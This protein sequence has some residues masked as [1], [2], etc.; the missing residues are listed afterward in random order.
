MSS[1][2]HP[3]DVEVDAKALPLLVAT[4]SLLDLVLR[5]TTSSID[6]ASVYIV[7][8]ALAAFL[9]VSLED[10]FNG[11]DGSV[12][13]EEVNVAVRALRFDIRRERQLSRTGR[14]ETITITSGSPSC[15]PSAAPTTISRGSIIDDA[16]DS[17][18]YQPS[19]ILTTS[20]SAKFRGHPS[21][22][23]YHPHDL[24]KL[25]YASFRDSKEGISL[26]DFLETSADPILRSVTDT[27][28][29]PT[30]YAAFAAGEASFA[31]PM[32]E[33]GSAV[34]EG[35]DI[36]TSIIPHSDA[37]ITPSSADATTTTFRNDPMDVIFVTMS[38]LIFFAMV[39]LIYVH[40]ST[41][42]GPSH[43]ERIRHFFAPGA[44]RTG[45]SASIYNTGS[46]ENP[47][48][49]AHF[50]SE[51][52]GMANDCAASEHR[53]GT[54]RRS[55]PSASVHVPTLSKYHYPVPVLQPRRSSTSCSHTILPVLGADNH[56]LITIPEDETFASPSYFDP[57]NL[58]RVDSS[59]SEDV[60]GVDVEGKERMQLE[61]E[62]SC[63]DDI[64]NVT[65]KSEGLST[66]SRWESWLQQIM[67]VNTE[68]SSK[69]EEGEDEI[70]NEV[71]RESTDS[72]FDE[73]GEA[74]QHG[75]YSC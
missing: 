12:L 59:V 35:N 23:S 15:V 14:N 45:N 70:Q 47:I 37:Q 9:A 58:K 22:I 26:R 5:P 17:S 60:F 51:G 7:E 68:A 41:R 39:V 62:G 63:D 74:T 40:R 72:N 67:V 10:R 30:T 55:R 27:K 43:D 61:E 52:G 18:G 19:T 57:S 1:G 2:L 31:P 24:D 54:F 50:A 53:S 64:S 38:G 32:T 65:A 46:D 4:S 49:D 48:N 16:N 36:S 44:D 20:V 56:G 21:D 66:L 71:D 33:T 8:E 75:C 25:I 13:L 42:R 6:I 28:I 69:S 29:G 73:D 3:P 11:A 34:V